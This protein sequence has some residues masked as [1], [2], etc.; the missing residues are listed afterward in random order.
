MQS[1]SKGLEKVAQEIAMS[2]NDG[3]DSA[4]FRKVWGSMYFKSLAVTYMLR[5]KMF[6]GVE[7]RKFQLLCLYFNFL[8]AVPGKINKY[9]TCFKP[10]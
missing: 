5:C 10:D 9:T 7:N 8:C 6:Y 2:E 1:V 3:P 4:G